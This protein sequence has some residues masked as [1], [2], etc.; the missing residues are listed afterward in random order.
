MTLQVEAKQNPR[1][2]TFSQTHGSR[3]PDIPDFFP[4]PAGK[5]LFQMDF[6]GVT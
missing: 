2:L 3:I 4:D 5:S 1:S 6:L